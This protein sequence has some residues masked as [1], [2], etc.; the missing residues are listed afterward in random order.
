MSLRHGRSGSRRAYNPRMRALCI[1]IFCL[2]GC[3]QQQTPPTRVPSS[4]PHTPT[5]SVEPTVTL[6]GECVVPEDRTYV[7][8]STAQ[9]ANPPDD[10]MEPTVREDT[11]RTS[12]PL[13]VD[14]DGVMDT[15]VPMVPPGRCAPEVDYAIYVMRGECGHHVGRVTGPTSLGEGSHGGLRDLQTHRRWSE[16]T[17]P[18][19]PPGPDNVATLHEVTVTWVARDGVYEATSAEERQGVC[20]H[21]PIAECRTLS[22]PP[23]PEVSCDPLPQEGSV[24]EGHGYCVVDWGSPGGQSTALWCRGGRWVLEREANLPE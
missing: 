24:C 9:E 4:E 3:T 13:D 11:F 16:L 15:F 21:C 10:A 2:Q 20:H 5:A 6:Q 18:A 7:V 22:G 23:A 1:A 12:R 14:G 8:Q 17:D 19:R